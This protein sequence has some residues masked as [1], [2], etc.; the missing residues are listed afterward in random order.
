MP[1]IFAIASNATGSHCGQNANRSVFTCGLV[2]L[3]YSPVI[4]DM[5]EPDK[6][7]LSQSVNR[8]QESSV[9]VL[10]PVVYTSAVTDSIQKQTSG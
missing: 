1:L 9:I 6:P 8:Q 5:L 4:A 10:T 7:R 2:K 3:R